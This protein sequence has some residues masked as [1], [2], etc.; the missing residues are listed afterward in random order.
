LLGRERTPALLVEQLNAGT[1]TGSSS[2]ERLGSKTGLAA[3]A[4]PQ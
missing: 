2:D 3:M 1:S 4:L